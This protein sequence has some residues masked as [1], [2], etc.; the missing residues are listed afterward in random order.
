MAADEA[1]HAGEEN[2]HRSSVSGTSPRAHRCRIDS[3]T[4]SADDKTSGA[5]IWVCLPTYNEADNIGPMVDRLRDVFAA[6]G[7][8]GNI[9]V[10]DD[11]SPDGTGAIAD[12]LA[13]RYDAVHVLHRAAKEG[14]GPAYRD[15]FRFALSRGADLVIE[16]DCDF[17]HDPRDVPRLVAA[18]DKADVV[19]GSRYVRGGTVSNWSIPRRLISRV[20]CLYA[21]AVLGVGPRDL[22]GGFKCFRRKVLASLPLDE[23]HSAGYVFQIEMTYRA[24]LAGFIVDEIPIT[25]HERRAGTSKMSRSIIWEAAWRVPGLRRLRSSG[26]GRP[27]S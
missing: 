5:L 9:L 23:V 4:V 7:L 13:A 17:S 25:F 1:G 20:G 27:A 26:A 3:R 19:L 15:G 10:I 2:A 18:A 12:D 22:T 21:Q 24:I 14:I 11:A 16:M 6:S 8:K